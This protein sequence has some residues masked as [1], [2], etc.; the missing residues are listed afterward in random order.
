MTDLTS[1]TRSLAER[2][3]ILCVC[4][5]P[6]LHGTPIPK[7]CLACQGI[8]EIERLRAAI[9]RIKVECHER[10]IHV[11]CVAALGSDNEETGS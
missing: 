11:M 3:R 2:L 7:P 9:E 1:K 10:R 6:S 8:D 4:G 5:Q